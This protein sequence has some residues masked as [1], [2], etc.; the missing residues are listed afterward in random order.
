VELGRL[1]R[2]LNATALYVTH[3]QVEAMT[4]GRR[5]ALLRNGRLEQLATP[6]AIYEHPENV[7]TASFFGSPPMNLWDA[8]RDDQGAHARGIRLPAPPAS[9]QEKLVFGLRPEHVEISANNSDR[10]QGYAHFSATVKNLEPLGAETHLELDVQGQ[11]LKARVPG[12]D[13][14]G[15]GRSIYA[16]FALGN[17]RWFDRESGRSL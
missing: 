13:A 14:P 1:L 3:D 12:L 7:F 11:T 15:V 6:R 8:E 17:V 16:V 4:L 2:E 10:L 5:I 9:A